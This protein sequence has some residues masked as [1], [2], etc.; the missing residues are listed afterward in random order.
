M[1]HTFNPITW[2]EEQEEQ[3]FKAT[4]GYLR[5]NQSKKETEPGGGG[6]NL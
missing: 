2:E 4:L 3:E 1:A 5:L 6:P